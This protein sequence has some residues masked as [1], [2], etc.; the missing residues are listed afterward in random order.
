MSEL[1]TNSVKSP[2]WINIISIIVVLFGL[3]TIKEGGATLFTTEGRIAAGKYVPFVLWFNFIAGFIYIVAGI[4][5]FKH[6]TCSKRLSTVIAIATTIVFILF[7]IHVLNGGEYE[8]RTV[9]AMTIR[10]TLWILI[11]FTIFRS[12]T[13]KIINCNC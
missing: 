5:I 11:A 4:A 1:K 12:K 10:S 7:G 13:F 8:V 3:A 6:K 2:I 9:V